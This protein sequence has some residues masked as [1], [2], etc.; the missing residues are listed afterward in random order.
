MRRIRFRIGMA[1]CLIA[2]TGCAT[3]RQKLTEEEL[4]DMRRQT[5]EQI[6]TDQV[7]AAT[8]FVKRMK[9]EQD[10]YEAAVAKGEHPPEPVFDVL[11]ISGGGDWGAF[12][13]GVLKG[14]GSVTGE[15]ARPQFDVVTG[16]STGA[17]IAPFAFLGTEQDYDTIRDLYRNPRPDWV[18][19]KDWFFFLP[20][21]ESFTTT[22]GLRRDVEKSLDAQ[23][24]A[25][26][27]EASIDDRSLIIGTTN[28]D[29]GINRPFSLGR[30]CE[31]AAKSGDDSLVYDVLMASSAVP[32]A[33]PPQV[34]DNALYVDGGTTANILAGA[35]LRSDKSLIGMWNNIYPGRKMS[36]IRIWVLIN[37]QMSDVPK[38]VSPTWP[39]ITSSA[40][41]TMSRFSNISSMRLLDFQVELL[42]KVDHIDAEYLYIAVPDDFR[43]PVQGTFKKE[44]MQALSDLGT[45]L[46]ADPASWKNNLTLE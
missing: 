39:S 34:I 16:V 4:L 29:L 9:A 23:A 42:N 24:I 41:T 19:L 22:T 20:W 3:S 2:L 1:V 35:N 27:A 12:G 31:R 43:V 36:K 37:N 7:L 10:A 8:K 44:T 28:L 32:A 33:F 40:L 46:G 14:W 38:I 15:R 13:S 18:E 5:L 21:R 17:L 11:V 30:I 25:R 45:K 6:K 26:V